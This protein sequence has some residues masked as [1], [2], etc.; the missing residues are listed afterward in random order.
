[1]KR[2]RRGTLRETLQDLKTM[3]SREKIS[4]I[5][6]YYNLWIIGIVIL[7]ILLVEAGKIIVNA[8]VQTIQS[9]LVLNVEL[10]DELRVCLEDDFLTF[11]EGNPKK[12]KMEVMGQFYGVSDEDQMYSYYTEMA[13]VAR[14]SAQELDYLI[15]EENG[16]QAL[17]RGEVFLDLREL[18]PEETL[19]SFGD[20]VLYGTLES[21]ESIPV[22][23]L[24]NGTEFGEKY[25]PDDQPFYLLFFN[26]SARMD[27]MGL[28]LSYLGY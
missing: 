14:I 12:Q 22:G 1:M 26:S 15:T 4:H 2:D 11:A 24:L 17:D 28:T 8:R 9:G 18:L 10:T 5:W 20:K 3:S 25:L 19:G 7:I 27:S 13:I 16:F 23:L 21:G 6:E